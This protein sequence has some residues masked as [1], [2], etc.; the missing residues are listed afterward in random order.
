MVSTERRIHDSY[1][2][3]LVEL[4]EGEGKSATQKCLVEVRVAHLQINLKMAQGMRRSTG[5][6]R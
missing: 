3:V 4:I 5:E 1:G 2:S 6:R